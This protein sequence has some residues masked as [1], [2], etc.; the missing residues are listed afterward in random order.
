MELNDLCHVIVVSAK[1]LNAPIYNCK[2][3]QH[4]TRGSS[5]L[6]TDPLFQ[7]AVIKLKE[8]C[9]HDLADDVKQV[10]QC[11]QLNNWEARV[12]NGDEEDGE[13]LFISERRKK[14]RKIESFL[15]RYMHCN[16][17]LGSVIDVEKLCSNSKWLFGDFRH[18]LSPI[19]LEALLFLRF[20][21]RF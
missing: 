3:G 9:P 7:S 10:V 20:Y 12:V 2:L 16:F 15:K 19:M 4:C 11:L 13:V 5:H 6:V 21:E 17:I 1:K 14:R 18:S 8:N